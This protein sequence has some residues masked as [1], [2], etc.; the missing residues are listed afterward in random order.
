MRYILQKAFL[1][2]FCSIFMLVG[3]GMALGGGG[4]VGGLV[5]GGFFFLI[6]LTV[7]IYRFR[8]LTRFQT[9]TYAWYCQTHPKAVVRNRVTCWSCG[10]GK[11]HARGLMNRTYHR[12]HFCVQCGLALYY[13]PE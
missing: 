8:Q 7:L 4:D 3:L 13:S 5:I 1:V 11:V 9:M 10:S 2:I 6:G 12:E